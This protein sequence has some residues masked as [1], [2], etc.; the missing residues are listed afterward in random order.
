MF[1]KILKKLSYRIVN[2]KNDGS[3]ILKSNLK[4]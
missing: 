4:N 3:S 1:G 2:F